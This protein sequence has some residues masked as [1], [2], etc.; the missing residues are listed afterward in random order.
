MIYLI[1][2]HGFIGSAFARLLSRRGEPYTIITRDN[3]ADYRDTSCRLLINA[4]GNSRKY[5][6]D[7]D[8]LAEFEASVTSVAR[9]LA[10]YRADTYL[11]LSTG[12]VYPDTSAPELTDEDQS[13]D[14]SR[15]SRYGLHKHLAEHLVRGSHP[16][17]TIV[18]MGGFVGQGLVKN[19]IYDMQHGL[20]LR[21][22]PDSRLQFIDV[23][24]AAELMLEAC[25]RS[26]GR[27]ILNIGGKGTIRLGDVH[28]RLGSRSLIDAAAPRVT[29]ELDTSRLEALLATTLPSTVACVEEH[30]RAVPPS[31]IDGS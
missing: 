7:R 6:A 31:T 18:R 15:Q 23:D 27:A 26:S 2:G 19:P 11:L 1:G 12:D 30:L 10:W 21:L 13:I 3:A 16:C 28:A 24:R 20:P 4:N 5:L 22:H 8:P 25:R 17:F 9:S 14:P 29:Y